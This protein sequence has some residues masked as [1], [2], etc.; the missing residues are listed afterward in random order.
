MT[1]PTIFRNSIIIDSLH[2]RRYINA[3]QIRTIT[4][5]ETY[6]KLAKFVGV[7]YINNRGGCDFP[8]YAIEGNL[9]LDAKDAKKIIINSS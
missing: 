7:S 8:I 5:I 4:V 3:H 9:I 1:G 6:E 2:H